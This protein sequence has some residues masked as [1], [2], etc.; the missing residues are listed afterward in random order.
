VARNVS[1]KLINI[2]VLLV[3]GKGYCANDAR[4]IGSLAN[5]NTVEDRDIFGRHIISWCLH[6]PGFLVRLADALETKFICASFVF[7][8]SQYQPRPRPL[9]IK[10][11]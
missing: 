7:D 11:R 5:I 9:K 1:S 8:T 4:Y 10:P 3:M 2:L 6:N